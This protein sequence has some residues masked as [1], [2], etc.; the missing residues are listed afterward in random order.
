MF[1]RIMDV[2]NSRTDSRHLKVSLAKSGIRMLA[3]V[4]LA[5]GG[6]ILAGALLIGAEVLGVMEEF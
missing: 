5:F 6:L 3:G 1:K 2:I 4:C